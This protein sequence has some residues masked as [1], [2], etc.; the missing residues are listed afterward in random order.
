MLHI[1]SMFMGLKFILGSDRWQHISERLV[2]GILK[3]EHDA[4]LEVG[5]DMGSRCVK[6]PRKDYITRRWIF[7]RKGYHTPRVEIDTSST[8]SG[9]LESAKVHY[10]GGRV[11]KTTV[12]TMILVVCLLAR[13]RSGRSVDEIDDE[14]SPLLLL[15]KEIA[16]LTS[17]VGTFK[18][19]S[20]F[21]Y[22][23]YSSK[24]FGGSTSLG[25]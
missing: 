15:A 21:S 14:Q 19:F 13:D 2:P 5:R 17:V 25:E 1:E 24:Y 18:R 9:R 4:V 20:R 11:Y 6:I 7:P 16:S 22:P 10:L 3:N 23:C 8:F 12:H